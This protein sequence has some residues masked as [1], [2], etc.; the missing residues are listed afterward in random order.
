[1]DLDLL[2]R[3]VALMKDGEL[4]E[5]EFEDETQRVRLSRR[6]E[7]VAGLPLP[8]AAAPFLAPAPAA[9]PSAA[10]AAANEPGVAVFRAPMVGTFYR[11]A[12]PEAEPYIQVGDRVGPQTTL[13]ILEAMKVMNEIKA[14]MS[15]EVVAILVENGEP[16]EFGQP[17]FKIKTA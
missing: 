11:A 10:A 12:G 4:T 6:R 13:C 14:E 7:V 16:V 3:L 15:G 9:A 17:M 1:M 2:Q 5:L 8:A